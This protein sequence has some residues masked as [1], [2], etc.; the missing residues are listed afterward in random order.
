M[1]VESE[2]KTLITVGLF[3]YV[4][5]SYCYHI[6]AKIPKGLP[7]LLA[8]LPV[9]VLLFIFPFKLHSIYLCHPLVLCLS[10]HTNFNLLS[11]AFDRG[12][13]SPPKAADLDVFILTACSPFKIKQ[14]HHSKVPLD[15][16]LEAASKGSLWIVFTLVSYS[17]KE[18]FHRLVWLLIFGF[19]VWLAVDV[20][21]T[22]VVIPAQVIL[23]VELEPHFNS[24]LL[25]SSLQDFW[26]RRWNLRVSETLRLVVYD[27]IKSV[28]IRLIG[29][30][31]SSLPPVFVTFVVSGLIHELLYYS[32]LRKN[33]T[34]EITLF[35]V[36]HGIFVDME[37][38]LKKKLKLRLHR[39]I[40]GP[41]AMANLTVTSVCLVLAPLLRNRV[42]ERIIYEF[43]LFLG[44]FSGL[45]P[46]RSLNFQKL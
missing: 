9:M 33:P 10:C 32:I 7:R 13:L 39:A 44:F 11:L 35:F 42:D 25:A 28:S 6:A 27:P 18:C 15:L 14:P 37:I 43:N 19:Q 16:I 34:W 29:A 46:W 5:L 30:R 17:Y 24:P 3:T 2:L 8:L 23:R 20:L 36:L 31:W 41:L 1:E 22:M 4:S 26:G 38:I 21:L 12:P 40:T 45:F